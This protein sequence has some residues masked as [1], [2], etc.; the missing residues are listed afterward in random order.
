MPEHI[1]MPDITPIIRYTADGATK[2]FSYDFPIFASEDLAV[3]LDG[4]KQ[5]SGFSVSG[6]G[7]TEGGTVTFDSAPANGVTVTLERLMPIERMSDFIEGGDFSAAA[8]NTE[9]DF[10]TAAV[11]QVS[12][13]QDHMLRYG[14][15]EPPGKVLVPDRAKRKNQVLGFDGDGDPVAV[16]TEGTM[17]EPDFTAT[18]TGAVTRT[19][20]DKFSDMISVKDFGAVGDGLTDDTTAI[21]QALD[22]HDT[23]F[24]P[25]GTYLITTTIT[26]GTD[27]A[28]FGA[29]QLSII[30]GQDNGFNLI[31]LAAGQARIAD[32]RL[33]AGDAAIKLFG[34]DGPCVQNAVTDVTIAGPNTGLLLDGHDDS[35]KPCD[36]NNF[37]R[38]LIEK[39][40]EQGIHITL[41]GGGNKP[42]ANR[43]S[44]VRVYSNGTA[45]SGA[46]IY[47]ENARLNTSFSDC[48]ADVA[49]TATAYIRLGGGSEKTL[50]IN[51]YT[52]STNQVANIL[53]DN[54]STESVINNLLSASN[55]AAIEDNSG[56]DYEAVNAGYPNKNRLRRSVVTDLRAT[57]MRYDTEFVD[58]T[59]TVD[60]D[61]SH[62]VHLVSAFNGDVEMKL[63]AAA[64][65]SGA[66]VMIKKTDAK[67][68]IIT[69]TE[70]NG[71][72]PDGKTLQLGGEH[73][74]MI[75]VSNG[76]AWHIVAS[77]RIAGNTRFHDG[78]GT[79]A[80]D[81]TVD[82]YLLSAF[83]GALD[84]ELPPADAPEASGRTV[85]IKK[86]DSS[87]NA[88]TVIEQ[89]G[90]GPDQ[91][92]Q[93]LGT[94][95]DAITVVSDGNEW[96]V[97]SK[98]S[99]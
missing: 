98:Y 66:M 38:I 84:A 79:Y 91:S 37:A 22:A 60:V 24:V 17:A 7:Q 14:D 82:V 61:T 81:M 70:D 4:A 54:G 36:W 30:K 2:D 43:F 35:T 62:S 88:V 64:D 80:I 32:L 89:G 25:D 63:P 49:G 16:S 18:G 28:L 47:V 45:I 50:L 85:T 21:Q 97:V 26:L 3:Y 12:R 96:L 67:A 27:Q 53:L 56:G 94:Q 68:H 33:E 39:P 87:A 57:L 76:A 13:K 1:Q 41:S 99:A 42:A 31:E 5:A 83:S 86:T 40:A 59:G 51:P 10:L 65:A 72:G 77:N 90:N 11:Q 92:N 74:Y 73:D 58:T 19:S 78:T 52:R 55:G 71:N 69:I 9:L 20:H 8:L 75:A 23:V 29:G 95:Y 34:K 44:M 46:G 15:H 6:A 93:T 48:E